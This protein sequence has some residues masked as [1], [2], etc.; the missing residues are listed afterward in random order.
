MNAAARSGRQAMRLAAPPEISVQSATGVDAR[1]VLAGPGARSIAFVIDWLIRAAASFAWYL[2]SS[3]ALNGGFSL[4]PPD[5]P[6]TLYFLVVV[7]PTLAIYFLY[8]FVLEAAMRGRTPGKRMIGLR[9]MTAE[10]LTPTVGAILTR[11]IF[12]LIDS[13]PLTYV[14]GLSFVIF[15]RRHLRLGDIAAGT[16]LALDRAPF[17][18]K[19][20]LAS[21]EWPER[22]RHALALSRR[23]SKVDDA[24]EVAADYSRAAHELGVVRA[25]RADDEHLEATYA[26]LHDTLHRPAL[27][28]LEE[29][30]T[31][32]RDRIPEAPGAMRVHLFAVTLLFITSGI[33]GTWLVY[34]YPDQIA[35][36][37]SPQLIATVERGELWTDGMLNVAPSAV[38]SAQLLTN[39]IVV[40][41]TAFCA[42]L[43]FGI[44]TFYIIAL[45][46]LMLG[47]IFTFTAQHDLAGRLFDFV[48][49]HGCVE[50]SAICVAGAAGSWMG[51]ALIRPRAATR[52]EAFREAAGEG[53]RVLAAVTVLLFICGFI[54]GYISPDPEVPRWARVTIGV[55]FW[56][57]MI[58]LLRG[59]VFGR[60]RAR[61]TDRALP[62][63]SP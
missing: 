35:L 41:F 7:A 5:G 52:S 53:M 12:R 2:L 13:M 1:I 14:V 34:T 32:F 40:A 56:L 33:A 20:D 17:L 43:L 29:I 42:G 44:G 63:V 24:L 4:D 26:D 45:N 54:E 49:P 60:D 46:G 18:E 21:G 19:Q 55:G 30:V 11:N 37:A 61:A 3:W 62:V 16:V 59:T 36:F 6:E 23:A 50:L 28:P 27:R 48:V 22:R 39:N 15:S 38:L 9:V 25:A 47:A 58:S 57:L 10:G 8:H 31:L 51:E